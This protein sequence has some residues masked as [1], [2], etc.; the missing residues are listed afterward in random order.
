[1]TPCTT[2]L[3][4]PTWLPKA[5]LLDLLASLF[6]TSSPRPVWYPRLTLRD[7]PT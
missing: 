5:F 3:R 4:S 7:H 6:A 1:M 2:A